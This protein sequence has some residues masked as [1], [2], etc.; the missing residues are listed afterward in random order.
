MRFLFI[1]QDFPPETGGIQT[2]SYELSRRLAGYYDYFCVLA[3]DTKGSEDFDANSAVNIQRFK[4]SNTFLFLALLFRMPGILKRTGGA[5]M[6]FHA[7][8]QT[9]PAAIVAK[10]RGKIRCIASAAHARE[11]L[12]NPFGQGFAGR[13]YKKYQKWLMNHVDVW[14]PVSEYTASLLTEHGVA[15]ER[16]KVLINGTDTERYFPAS[17]PGFKKKIGLEHKKIILTVTR[18]VGRKGIDLVIRSMADVLKEIP[19]AFYLIVGDGPFRP[20]LEK[21]IEQQ[22]LAAS[23]RLQGSVPYKLLSKYYNAADVFVMPSRTENPDVEGFGIVFLEA[24]AC[25]IPVVGS[26]SGGIPSAIKHGYNGLVVEENNRIKL[27]ESIIKI[28]KNKQLAETL[29]DNGLKFVREK[30][31]WDTVAQTLYNHLKNEIH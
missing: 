1:T 31:N 10:K 7:Q 24:N 20:E 8:W 15:A 29:G 22:N 16:I 9:L 13:V 6:V 27:T 30:A 5:D 18:L 21:L 23:V 14:F 26:D 2:Y 25:A 12:Y 11:L 3:P 17:A 19:D 28:L 4:I